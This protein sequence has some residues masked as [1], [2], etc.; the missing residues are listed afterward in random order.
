MRYSMCML[1]KILGKRKRKNRQALG[2]TSSLRAKLLDKNGKELL[3]TKKEGQVEKR[4]SMKTGKAIQ[5]VYK[6]EKIVHLHCKNC[7]NEWK[8][9][10]GIDWTGKFEVKGI[11]IKCLKCSKVYVSG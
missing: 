4:F 8:V 3:K 1:K 9:K 5:I 7:G 11:N 10:E 6:D 2:I